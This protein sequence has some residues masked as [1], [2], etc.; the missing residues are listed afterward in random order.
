METGIGLATPAFVDRVPVMEDETLPILT[1]PEA[2]ANVP[3]GVAELVLKLKG[4]EAATALVA[5]TPF[6][7][8]ICGIVPPVLV[9][10]TFNQ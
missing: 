1:V 3:V 9:E 6:I 5:N 4:P 8:T 10:F 7:C 2:L